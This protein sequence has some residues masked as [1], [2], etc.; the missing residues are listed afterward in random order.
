MTALTRLS[1]LLLVL[2]VSTSAAIDWVE[3]PAQTEYS[4]NAPDDGLVLG[5]VENDKTVKSEEKD[6]SFKGMVKRVTKMTSL[7]L[8][9][10]QVFMDIS[11]EI[12]RR[13]N[14]KHN[15]NDGAANNK[16]TTSL[17][18]AQ[19]AMVTVPLVYD[20]TG[21]GQDSTET[22]DIFVKRYRSANTSTKKIMFSVEGGPGPSSEGREGAVLDMDVYEGIKD[23]DF[24][25]LDHRG[26]GRS[27]YV[28]C[29]E[30][31]SPVECAELVEER[32]GEDGLHWI[33]TTGMAYDINK[34]IE[35]VEADEGEKYVTLYGVSYGT[36]VANRFM[37]IFPLRAEL[38]I[39]DGVCGLLQCKVGPLYSHNHHDVVLTFMSDVCDADE[40]CSK[41]V[42]CDGLSFLE[43][44]MQGLKNGTYS[45]CLTTLEISY[46]DV[47]DMLQ[48]F[49]Q[50]SRFGRRN[51]PAL[52]KRL[53]R[54]T[55]DDVQDL[56]AWYQNL[57][58]IFD[59]GDS[60]PKSYENFYDLPYSRTSSEFLFMNI[61]VSEFFDNYTRA[62]AQER[63][64]EEYTGGSDNVDTWDEFDSA[65]N[66]WPSLYRHS[67]PYVNESLVDVF[68]VVVI[69]GDLDGQTPMV[70][71]MNVYDQ[72]IDTVT[73]KV[74][75]GIK[76]G[77]HGLWGSGTSAY[78]SS[79]TSSCGIDVVNAAVS[80]SQL[81]CAVDLECF[82]NLTP[83]P[84][85]VSEMSEIEEFLWLGFGS[86]STTTCDLA[87]TNPLRHEAE[88][89]D[90]LC[91]CDST[92]NSASSLQGGF[93]GIVV[94]AVLS[95]AIVL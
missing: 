51:I 12:T 6:M 40:E 68:A 67:D 77:G 63:Y 65:V 28:G 54:C 39:I 13:W 29:G 78:G 75:A 86:D 16:Q 38:V 5:A 4:E 90:S 32:Y 76:Y 83:D 61:A 22:I 1:P 33:S 71:A 73:G 50:F 15:N 87:T 41:E 24:Y 43:D 31:H 42:G 79:N 62:E 85:D 95:F 80:S 94:L 30:D 23:F 57:D 91:R 25:Y 10:N 17:P 74:L 3:C 18:S 14:K 20:T 56:V 72:R 82:D 11:A 84:F 81:E 60:E 47:R 49:V 27:N 55:E 9:S 88:C 37:T 36:F 52:L 44:S 69:N 8:P 59:G 19:C 21:A 26:T 48:Q 93:V 66:N 58:Q 46:D 53:T 70:N 45:T 2:V 89:V 7:N 35:L 64:D 34:V 92:T